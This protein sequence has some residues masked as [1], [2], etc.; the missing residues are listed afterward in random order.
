MERGPPKDDGE[1]LER[2][3]QIALHGRAELDDGG[4]ESGPNFW[5]AFAAF[6]P[7]RVAKMTDA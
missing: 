1:Y 7:E 6:S 5:K 3:E 2:D 4:E